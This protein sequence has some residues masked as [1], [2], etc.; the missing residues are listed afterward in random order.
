V[1]IL[2]EPDP[3]RDSNIAEDIRHLKQKIVLDNVTF[4]YNSSSRPSLVNCN[5]ILRAGT[6]T[7]LVGRSGSGKSTAISLLLR[8]YDPTSGKQHK[9]TMLGK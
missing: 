8:F 2:Q 1:D 3:L 9:N 7:A 4:C 5:L 6:T